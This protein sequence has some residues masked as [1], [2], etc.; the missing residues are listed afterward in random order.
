MLSIG[1]MLSIGYKL[2]EKFGQNKE[3]QLLSCPFIAIFNF[4]GYSGAVAK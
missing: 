4:I 1:K 3:Q 2:E